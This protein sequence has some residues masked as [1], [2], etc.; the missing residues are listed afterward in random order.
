MDQGLKAE[1]AA[2]GLSAEDIPHLVYAWVAFFWLGSVFQRHQRAGEVALGRALAV[3]QLPQGPR[4]V[5]SRKPVRT[6]LGCTKVRDTAS[7]HLPAPHISM[8]HAFV[9]FLLTLLLNN[10]Q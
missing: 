7:I 6:E 2:L 10:Q 9:S 4:S 5:H 3:P 8:K 1:M